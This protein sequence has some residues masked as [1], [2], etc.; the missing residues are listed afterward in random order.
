MEEVFLVYYWKFGDGEQWG[1]AAADHTD[2]SVPGE[3]SWFE[4]APNF[5]LQSV[6]PELVGLG[7]P[8]SS[9]QVHKNP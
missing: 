8:D 1:R 9:D 3:Y 6:L 7:A 5:H 4:R 2:G